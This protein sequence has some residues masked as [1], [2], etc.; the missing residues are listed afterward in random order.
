MFSVN[1]VPAL[2]PQISSIPTSRDPFTILYLGRNTPHVPQGAARSLIGIQCR[3]Y[4]HN[5]SFI[6]LRMHSIAWQHT[7]EL[8]G[9]G[10][11]HACFRPES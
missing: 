6:V 8:S 9:T 1:L 5:G 7:C 3:Q 2:L 10:E 11:V 4:S